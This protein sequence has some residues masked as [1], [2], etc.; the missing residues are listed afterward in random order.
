MGIEIGYRISVT[1]VH[2][3]SGM[4]LVA[5]LIFLI[6]I[7]ISGVGKLLFCF[8]ILSFFSVSAKHKLVLL[9]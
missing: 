7:L 2:A 5:S 6:R 4:L 8:R 1:P 9:L 3:F